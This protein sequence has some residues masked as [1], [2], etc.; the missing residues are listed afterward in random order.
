MAP[1][2]SRWRLFTLVVA[3]CL[4]VPDLA[5]RARAIDV[6]S[7]IALPMEPYVIPAPCLLVPNLAVRA[8]AMDVGSVI[9]L[10]M[11]PYVI[12]APDQNV[13]MQH[14]DK[15]RTGA[16]LNERVLTPNAVATRGLQL[17]Y[18]R[19]VDGAINA[20]L[21]YTPS[22]P[23]GPRAVDVVFVATTNGTVY[24]YDANAHA[25][26]GTDEGLL[27]RT[28]LRGHDEDQDPGHSYGVHSTP[29][30]D[31]NAKL[32][33]IVSRTSES[34]TAEFWLSALDI[35]YGNIVRQTKIAP[36]GFLAAWQNQRPALLLDRG[37]IYI[38]FGM[39]G[40]EGPN[41]YHGWVLRYD[42]RSFA[43]AGSFNP[44]PVFK[45]NKWLGAGVWHGGGG[46]AADDNG[47]VYA[48]TGNG[49]YNPCKL[50][51]GDSFIKL[52]LRNGSWGL[53]DAFAPREPVDANRLADCDLDLGAGGPLLI[54]G[55][56]RLVGGGK[57]G[58][59]YV[60]DQSNLQSAP[61]WLV[62]G[63]Y[64][65]HQYPDA[66]RLCQWE[67]GPHLHGSP[68]FWHGS[69][70]DYVY[71]WAE[72]DYLRRF[73]F[74]ADG[75]LDP[76][77]VTGNLVG[78]ECLHLNDGR[79]PPDGEMCPMPGG[80]LS[81]SADGQAA[82]ILWS[83]LPINTGQPY[84]TLAGLPPPG[85]LLA[86]D[87]ETMKLLWRQD[88]PSPFV[89][90]K[91]TPPTIADGKVFIATSPPAGQNGQFLVYELGPP[92]GATPPR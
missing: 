31:L 60:L 80:M 73:A 24:A 62:G 91:W 68:A 14:N 78:P 37:M 57:T 70:G 18:V 90:G 11:E 8:R 72:Q 36:P 54:Q 41:E 3:A 30:I 25:A 40:K 27:W 77:P 35:R 22:L 6:G 33:Y 42:A 38:G 89:L 82:G 74:R 50:Q 44:N 45:A 58:T 81:I 59:L 61:R 66:S 9:A 15:Y 64:Q 75:T 49:P 26:S 71:I 65:Y 47:D 17:S 46:L 7:V 43:L 87:A 21:L 34:N 79:H 67:G 12:P 92:I 10:P 84:Y 2:R 69:A 88:L 23:I 39:F 28:S 4:L 32:L 20:Q 51:F 16:Y 19:P 83:T 13:L 86:Y 76:T 52:G 56:N 48:M 85:Q 63:N 55:R 5:V 1:G 53:V 29:V